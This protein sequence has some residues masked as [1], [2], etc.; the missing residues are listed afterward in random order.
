M[1]KFDALVSSAVAN[2]PDPVAEGDSKIVVEALV[3]A[4][5]ERAEQGKETYGTYLRTHNGRNSLV[6]AFQEILDFTLYM[7]QFFLE[8]EV[9]DSE[10]VTCWMCGGW[11]T[12][13]PLDTGQKTTNGDPVFVWGA[14]RAMYQPGS[15]DC[16][17]CEGSGKSGSVKVVYK[18]GEPCALESKIW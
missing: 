11:G 17:V 10:L 6:D 13:H 12:I 16:P 15:R 8:Q 5:L 1:S 14:S 7:T 18:E 4:L 9:D 3:E 2:E